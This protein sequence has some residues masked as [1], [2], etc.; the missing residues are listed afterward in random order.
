MTAVETAKGGI[1]ISN[2]GKFLTRSHCLSTK[3]N[4]R[5]KK[6]NLIRTEV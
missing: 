5:W 1:E 3:R 6:K 2:K 4:E